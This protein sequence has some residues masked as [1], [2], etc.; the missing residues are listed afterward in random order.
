MALNKQD[1]SSKRMREADNF[2][3]TRN[4]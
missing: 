2:R 1:R 3:K 4:I